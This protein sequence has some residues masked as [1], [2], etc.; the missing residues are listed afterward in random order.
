MIHSRQQLSVDPSPALTRGLQLLALLNCEG[1]CSLERLSRHTGWPKSS[2]VRLLTSLV[3]GGAVRRDPVSKR[4]HAIMRLVP[5]ISEQE[6]TRS[7]GTS[8]IFKL[9]ASVDHTVELHT[10]DGQRLTMVDRCEPDNK[11]VKVRAR[12]G[13]NHDASEFNALTQIVL[14]SNSPGRHPPS[15]WYWDQRAIRRKI[16]PAMAISTLQKVREERLG[17]DLGIND[18]SVRRYAAPI[19]DSGQRLVAVLAVAQVC[20]PGDQRP[21]SSVRQAVALTAKQISHSLQNCFA[22]SQSEAVQHMS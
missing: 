10:Y 21:V 20:T 1:L 13:W 15:L 9:C 4:Y 17:V 2:V 22:V 12:I 6:L 18:N 14:A 5:L 8:A 7:L 11:E 16:K 3:N 19:L